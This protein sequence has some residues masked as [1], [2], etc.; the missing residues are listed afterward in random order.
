[1]DYLFEITK[2]LVEWSNANTGF[3]MALLTAVYVIATILIVYESR[4]N[5]RLMLMIE[6]DRTRPHVVFWVESE[7][8]THGKYFNAIDY[9]GKIRN[10]GA[11]TAHDIRIT[12]IPKL[13]AR[14]GIDKEGENAYYTPTFLE[15]ITSILVPNQTII[16]NIGPTKFLLEDNDDES[17]KFKIQIEFSDVGGEKYSTEYDI[18]LSKNR[19]CFYTEDSYAKAYFNLVEKATDAA[20]SLER[21]NRS[22]NQPD[23]SNMYIREDLELNDQQVELIRK[24][25][26][27]EQQSERKGAI[28]ERAL[29]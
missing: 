5:N 28:F 14:Q 20:K 15:E 13:R 2:I 7:M 10:E 29:Q 24:I 17:L 19:N 16:E 4:R 25:A 23:R 11:S 26:E 22:L 21:I 6:K 1:M 9:I 12:T 3:L 18:D 27:A 8:R